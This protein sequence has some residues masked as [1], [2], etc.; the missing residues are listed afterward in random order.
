MAGFRPVNC[1]N[2]R[3]AWILS[4]KTLT[5]SG[6]QGKIACCNWPYVDYIVCQNQTMCREAAAK[7]RIPSDKFVCIHQTNWNQSPFFSEHKEKTQNSIN[8]ICACGQSKNKGAFIMR[9]LAENLSILL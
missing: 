4:W 6:I 3:D 9:S 5:N 1:Q 2:I 7:Y 8:L